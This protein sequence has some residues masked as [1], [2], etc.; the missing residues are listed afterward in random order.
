MAHF[1]VPGGFGFVLAAVHIVWG[2]TIHER[3]NEVGALGQ[4]LAQV[5]GWQG[6]RDVMLLGD[7]NLE[8][9]DKAW[10]TTREAGW[11]PLLEGASLKSMVGDTNLYDNIWVS[12]ADTA[13][14]EWLGASGVIRF[15]K[16]LNFG[17]GKEAKKTAIKELSDHRP[18]WALFATDIDDDAEGSVKPL[19][20][21]ED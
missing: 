19:F 11:M 2:K 7:F 8:P 17:S 6:E 15:D 4:K 20:G 16:V 14:S 3:R 10:N 5:K 1:Q 9:T 18:C 21:K 12:H 13:S